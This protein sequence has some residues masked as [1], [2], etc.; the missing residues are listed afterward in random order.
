MTRVAKT[1][2]HAVE[3]AWRSRAGLAATEFA[4][5]LPIMTLT[6]FGML[7]SSDAFMENRRV[8][9]ASNALADL[10]SQETEGTTADIDNV[11]T[12][13][14]T[15]LEPTADSGIVVKIESVHVDPNNAN[16]LLVDWSRDNSGGTPYA[17]GA[18][19]DKIN[20]SLVSPS[21]SLIVVEMNFDYVSSLT[22]K[23][24]PMPIHFNRVVTRWPR[25]SAQV[26]LCGAAP[27][28]ACTI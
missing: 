26:V 28:P 19:F 18:A 5:I 27:L 20:V 17:N 25:Q 15:M 12:G 1:L 16:Q 6:F 3:R 21:A 8:A 11:M 9:N 23:V 13:V 7:E 14:T 24:L 2:A 10:I 22:H 4:L